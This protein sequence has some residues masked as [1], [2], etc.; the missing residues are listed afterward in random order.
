[1]HS[2]TLVRGLDYYNKTIFEFVSPL[3]VL[4]VRFGGGRY[5]SLV[6]LLGGKQDQ[7]S[8]GAAIGIDRFIIMRWYSRHYWFAYQESLIIIFLLSQEQQPL[9]LLSW[10]IL[11]HHKNAL[12]FYLMV[13]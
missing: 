7:P 6:A 4:K 1:M 5:D 12:I 9:A 13:L 3:L 8:I 10:T 11:R 2:T